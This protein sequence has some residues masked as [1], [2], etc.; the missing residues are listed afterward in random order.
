[1]VNITPLYPITEYGTYRV[2]A[3]VFDS[4]SKRYYSSAPPVNIEITE[5]RLLWQQ[6][7]GV[8]E[9]GSEGSGTRT[10]SLLSHSLPNDTQLY[11]RIEDKEKGLVYCTAQ[12]GRFIS[13]GKPSVQIDA[14]NE[15]NILQAVAPKMFLYTRAGVNGEILERKQYASLD[16]SQPRLKRDPAGNYAV[17]GGM[18]IDPKAIAEQQLKSGPPPSISDRPVP[19]P[20]PQ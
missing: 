16:S 13:F 15:V 2:R 10:I 3:T 9:P 12:I 20:K 1:M 7:V 6:T 8:P 11:L 4:T 19:L 5:G 17:V 18:F 14:Q